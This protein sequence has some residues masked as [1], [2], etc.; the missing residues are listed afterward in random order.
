[1]CIRSVIYI[2][3]YMLYIYSDWIIVRYLDD[4]YHYYVSF[5]SNYRSWFSRD[6]EVDCL[7]IWY[8]KTE[9]Y[10]KM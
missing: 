6:S 4:F 1:M 9:Y 2:I 10:N 8:M 3:L 7:N 5:I